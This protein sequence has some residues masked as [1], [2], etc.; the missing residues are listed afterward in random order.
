MR[1]PQTART[2]SSLETIRLGC[3]EKLLEPCGSQTSIRL[4][5]P[6]SASRS[7]RAPILENASLI[8]NGAGRR[9]QSGKYRRLI[10]GLSLHPVR[11][12]TQLPADLRPAVPGTRM[13]NR[14]LCFSAILATLSCWNGA[15]AHE[16]ES[17]WTYPPACCRG[18]KERG[19]CQEI[20]NT[21]V[22]AGPE[23]FKVLLNPGDHH[24]VT[25]QH[26]FRIPYGNTIPSGDSDFHICLYP[27]EHH[28]NCFF[29]P[30][31]GF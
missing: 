26:F 10:G 22:S 23:G 2:N 3:C 29:A 24:L 20:P 17:G 28:A 21:S 30:P 27:T 31:D 12:R 7:A 19:D 13:M 9:C 14:A 16:T 6:R 18:D 1:P 4:P 15:A 11:P 8:R 5:L 25:K